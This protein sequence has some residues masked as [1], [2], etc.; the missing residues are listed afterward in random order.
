MALIDMPRTRNLAERPATFPESVVQHGNT[1][2]PPW[3]DVQVVAQHNW[4][5]IAK[6]IT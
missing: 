2:D 3:N 4:S 1:G 5:R 6:P